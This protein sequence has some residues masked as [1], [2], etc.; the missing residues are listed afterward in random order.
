MYIDLI[1]MSQLNESTSQYDI[2]IYI[3]NAV[4]GA[5]ITNVVSHTRINHHINVSDRIV[6]AVSSTEWNT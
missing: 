4:D 5:N 3:Y 1:I 6:P 2:Y